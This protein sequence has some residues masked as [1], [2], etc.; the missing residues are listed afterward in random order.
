V[1]RFYYYCKLHRFSHTG[2]NL[3]NTGILLRVA[4]TRASLK[5]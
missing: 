5:K 2:R 4:P 1:I 3:P